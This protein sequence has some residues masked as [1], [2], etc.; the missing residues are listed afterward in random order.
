MATDIR[1]SMTPENYQSLTALLQMLTFGGTDTRD[2][3]GKTAFLAVMTGQ[4]RK[5]HNPI[6]LPATTEEAHG[7]PFPDVLGL[8]AG[9]I[10]ANIQA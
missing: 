9:Q 5:F 6:A 3:Q 10:L 4:R 7:L 1:M 2:G 8:I